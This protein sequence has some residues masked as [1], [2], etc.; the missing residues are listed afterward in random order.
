MAA[1]YDRHWAP[2]LRWAHG[3]LPRYARAL[4]DTADIVQDAL[5]HTLQRLTFIEPRG[6]KSLQLYLRRAVQNRIK[7]ELRR[8]ARHP[9]VALLEFDGHHDAAPGPDAQYLV[10]EQA[11]RYKAA[12][13]RLRPA[14]QELIVAR[15]ELE[16]TYEQ[17]ALMTG[18][19][20]P[21]AARMALSR[22]VVRLAQE[23]AGL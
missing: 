11:R 2:L 3:R 4:A 21:D 12:L 17:L 19:R 8:V 22:A 18:R 6:P 5:V 1:L 9:D 7:D 20:T 15:F 23:L 16:Y 14:D 10:A 13:A